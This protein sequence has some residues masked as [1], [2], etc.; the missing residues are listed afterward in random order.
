LRLDPEPFLELR[1]LFARHPGM[2]NLQHRFIKDREKI[3]PAHGR[4]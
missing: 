3:R 2:V 1:R 4:T